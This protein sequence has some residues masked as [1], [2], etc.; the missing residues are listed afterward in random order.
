MPAN[1]KMKKQEL[2]D[3]CKAYEQNIMKLEMD[4]NNLTELRDALQEELV[5]TIDRK[6]HFNNQYMK[7]K[8][9]YEELSKVSLDCSNSTKKDIIE[10]QVNMNRCNKVLQEQNK[11][12]QEANK[13]LGDTIKSYQEDEQSLIDKYENAIADLGNRET[14]L[15]NIKNEFLVVLNSFKV[16]IDISRDRYID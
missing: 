6:N 1:K 13:T 15:K 10:L 12:L 14:E 16:N 8:K 4:N 11:E 3:M 9:E 5:R 7:V 2:Y